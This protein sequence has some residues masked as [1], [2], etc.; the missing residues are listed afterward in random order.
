MSWWKRP[1]KRWE[2]THPRP[3][4]TFSL[5]HCWWCC[6]AMARPCPWQGGTPWPTVPSSSAPKKAATAASTGGK[7]FKTASCG[8]RPEDLTKKHN[9]ANFM[10]WKSENGTNTSSPKK[11]NIRWVRIALVS[12]KKHRGKVS[13]YISFDHIPMPNRLSCNSQTLAKLPLPK[14]RTAK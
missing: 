14:C 4:G 2:I 1:R 7:C 11:K 10:G 8:T 12:W 6:P 5:S 9:S 3:P 13:P